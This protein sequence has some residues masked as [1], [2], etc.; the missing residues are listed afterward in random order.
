MSP[1]KKHPTTQNDINN[2]D[3]KKFNLQLNNLN[4]SRPSRI[5]KIYILSRPAK[6]NLLNNISKILYPVI[7]ELILNNL[8]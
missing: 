8:S 2:Q 7:S 3:F 4:V 1:D 5:G 6:N